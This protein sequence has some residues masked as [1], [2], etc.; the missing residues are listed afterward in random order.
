MKNQHATVVIDLPR[1]LNAK[2]VAELL[3]VRVK[4]VYELGI[5]HV[6]LSTRSIRWSHDDVVRWIEQRRNNQPQFGR[7][8]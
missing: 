5:P 3:G 8:A 1:L 6:M 4:R 7:I 2:Q